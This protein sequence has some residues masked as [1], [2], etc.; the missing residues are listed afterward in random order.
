VDDGLV[1]AALTRARLKRAATLGGAVLV[2]I[3]ALLLV[4]RGIALGDALGERLAAIRPAAFALALA[5]YLFGSLLLGAVWVLLVRVAAGRPLRTVPLLLGHLRAQVA[6]YQPGNVFHLAWRHVAVAREGV[7]HRVPGA[8]L[9][10]ES[11]LLLAAAALL[12]L[13]VVADPRVQA[14]APWARGLVWGAPAAALLACLAL[15]LLSR[16]LGLAG[17][18]P[19]RAAGAF[20]G[21]LVLDLVFFFLA[22]LALRTL[23][24]TPDALPLPAWCGWLALAWALGYV[25]PGAPAG[26]GLREAVLG[27]GLAPVLGE[28]EALAVALAYRLLTLVSDGLLALAGFAGGWRRTES[29]ER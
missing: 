16:R 26:L 4:R 10:M 17:L 14:L 6:K 13:G 9:A 23:C 12:A 5:C 24:D 2:A 1:P 21:V 29:L 28:A 22:A 27:L 20:A 18:S 25:T 15:V 7:G 3:A 19:A 8:A 11:A